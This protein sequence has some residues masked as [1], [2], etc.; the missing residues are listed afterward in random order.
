MDFDVRTQ[1]IRIFRVYALT[2]HLLQINLRQ[3]L[4]FI[5]KKILV[6]KWLSN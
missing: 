3:N 6:L 5:A 2:Y 4:N 1:Q